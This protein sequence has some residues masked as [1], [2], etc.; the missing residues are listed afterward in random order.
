M[1]RASSKLHAVVTVQTEPQSIDAFIA[2]HATVSFGGYG[3]AWRGWPVALIDEIDRV[4]RHNDANP[5]ARVERNAFLKR[6]LEVHG[7]RV[8]RSSLDH[9]LKTQR[10]RKNWTHA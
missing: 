1:A 7:V 5:T 9:Y 3:E 4:I 2:S 6:A 10:G 8:G